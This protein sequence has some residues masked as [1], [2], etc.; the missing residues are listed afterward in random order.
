MFS[1]E[2]KRT[3]RLATSLLIAACAIP[4]SAAA[5]TGGASP[6]GTTSPTAPTDPGC[7]TGVGGTGSTS[8]DCGPTG[9]AKLLATGQ[10]VA[11]VNAPTAVKRA[12]RYANM[13]IDKPYR[14]GGG[15][16]LPWR[17]DS[18]YDCSGTASWALHGA[19]L[20]KA[21]MPSG[22]FVKWGAPGKG[23]WITVYAHGGH[24]YLVIAGL[25]LDTS[26]VPGSGP[27]WSKTLRTGAGYSV[28]HPRAY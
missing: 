4:A 16:R 9:K 6:G 18:A 23:R 10:A 24:M 13:I 20:L 17:I 15:H 25:R 27:G 7:T 3:G 21:P 12:I 19:R 1:R 11:P 5:G 22:S 26:Q 8:Q 28:R 14:L 2:T